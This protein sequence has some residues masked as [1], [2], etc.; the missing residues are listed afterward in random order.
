MD[1]PRKKPVFE[2]RIT[3]EILQAMRKRFLELPQEMTHAN[4]AAALAPE[5]PQFTLNT[6]EAY[7]SMCIQI[8]EEVFEM[9]VAGKISIT[10]LAE[11][12]GAWD[13]T[14]QKYIA[15]E[16]VEQG[17]TVTN[18]RQIK[19]LKREHSTMGFAE[20]IS[21]AKGEIPVGQ[22]RKEQKKS[23][24]Q[25]LTQI[26]DHGVRWRALVEMAFEMV[27]D[28]D[29]A[30]GVHEAIFEKVFILR[31]LVGEQYDAINSRVQ[32]YMN[33]IKKKVK[34][35]S[36]QQAVV[37]GEPELG[38]ISDKGPKMIDADFTERPKDGNEAGQS[39]AV[40]K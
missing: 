27:R 33:M 35:N 23:L 15:N 3:I 25:V 13:D 2:K 34:E 31:Q 39:P 21:R 38:P 40:E 6:L 16:F 5:F 14:T 29:T 32:R 8:C 18:L 19:Q 36:P 7:S 28:E 17:L 4:R 22:P 26:A 30:T 37:E 20:A 11:F 9:V 12:S 10:A 1:T 24:D